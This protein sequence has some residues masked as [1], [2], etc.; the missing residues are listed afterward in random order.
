[1]RKFQRMKQVVGLFSIHFS[2]QCT[3]IFSRRISVENARDSY[4]GK[5]FYSRKVHF[6]VHLFNNLNYGGSN[7]SNLRSAFKTTRKRKHV[8]NLENTLRIPLSPTFFRHYATFLNF[9]G[10]HQGSPLHLFRYF[11]TQWMSKNLKGS[12]F[13]IF[14]HCDTVQKSHLKKNFG[15]FFKVKGSPLL[16]VRDLDMAPT[17]A[18]LG[19][20]ASYASSKIFCF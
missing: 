15:K 20:F 17:L 5:F 2:T 3:P 12:P 10:L 13:Y 9:F 7:H 19:L 8:Q 4:S 1:M 16:Q 14:R 11:A 6:F 18:V